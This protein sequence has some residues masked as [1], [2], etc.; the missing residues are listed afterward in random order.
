MLRDQLS[1]CSAIPV[2]VLAGGGVSVL[3]MKPP[4]RPRGRTPRGQIERPRD[5]PRRGAKTAKHLLRARGYHL[6]CLPLS[7]YPE[8][9]GRIGHWRVDLWHKDRHDEYLHCCNHFYSYTEEG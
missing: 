4:R 7:A 8:Y 2:A 5:I 6:G 3:T 9:P 1:A